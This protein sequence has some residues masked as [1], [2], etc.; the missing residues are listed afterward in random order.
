[1]D[2]SFQVSEV[3]MPGFINGIL[4]GLK[5]TYAHFGISSLD[6]NS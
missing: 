5:L 3:K 4:D 1:M 2:I 6:R